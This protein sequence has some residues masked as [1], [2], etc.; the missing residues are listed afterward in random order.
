MNRLVLVVFVLLMC[1]VSCNT[2]SNVDSK[3]DVIDCV[4]N[5]PTAIIKVYDKFG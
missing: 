4:E 1:C 2:F 5:K 3:K